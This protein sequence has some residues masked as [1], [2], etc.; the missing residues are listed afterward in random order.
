MELFIWIPIM[1]TTIT[2]LIVLVLV[3]VAHILT[4]KPMRVISLNNDAIDFIDELQIDIYEEDY[5]ITDN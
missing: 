4:N 1:L 3:L 2:F 5:D